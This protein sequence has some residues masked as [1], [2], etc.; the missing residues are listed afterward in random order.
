MAR[1]RQL[2]TDENFART[3]EAGLWIWGLQVFEREVLSVNPADTL[4]LRCIAE[5]VPAIGFEVAQMADWR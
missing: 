5:Q 3:G 1:M 2:E 4:A